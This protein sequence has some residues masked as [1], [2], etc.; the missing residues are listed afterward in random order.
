MTGLEKAARRALDALEHHTEQTRPIQRTK[1]AIASLRAALQQAEPVVESHKRATD[2][3]D[4][5]F[6]SQADG[7]AS[8]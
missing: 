3:T 4:G 8:Y 7:N 2:A 6:M 5:Q 1:E